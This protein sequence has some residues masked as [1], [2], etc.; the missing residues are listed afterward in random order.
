VRSRGTKGKEEVVPKDEDQEGEEEVLVQEKQGSARDEA[1]EQSKNH[2]KNWFLN[3]GLCSF[4]I[5]V[6]E[7]RGRKWKGVE[8]ETKGGGDGDECL[9]CRFKKRC[10]LNNTHAASSV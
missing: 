8:Q 7:C 1:E 6:A 9:G 5:M 3:V 10:R 4:V 2:K